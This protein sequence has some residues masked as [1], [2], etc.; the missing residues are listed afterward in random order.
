M[1]HDASWIQG[2]GPNPFESINDY[3]PNSHPLVYTK[4]KRVWIRCIIIYYQFHPCSLQ[5]YC[6][7]CTWSL[8]WR[9]NGRDSVSNHQPHDC[10]LNRLF[11]RRSNKTPKLRVTG[12]CMGI[13]RGP[14]NSPHKWPVT[15]KMFPFDD[16]IM[17][18]TVPV[19]QHEKNVGWCI[20]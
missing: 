1:P 20:F 3:S 15:R 7:G 4:H 16:V 10:L 9:H 12:L 5:G 19:K 13:H 8:H 11:R 17:I 18:A 14:V 2:L 6:T